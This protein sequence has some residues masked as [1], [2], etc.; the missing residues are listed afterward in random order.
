MGVNNTFKTKEKSGRAAENKEHTDK[1]SI[2]Q[3]EP[4]QGSLN[5]KC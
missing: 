4:L 5:E 2:I 1:P 3:H